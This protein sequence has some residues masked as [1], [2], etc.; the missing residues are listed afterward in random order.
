MN[1]LLD[2]H[3]VIVLA[4][5]AQRVSARETALLANPPGRLVVSAVSIWE[6][7]LKWDSFW[8]SCARKGPV[9]PADVLRV[10]AILTIDRLP[11]TEAHASADLAPAL[12]HSDP[13]DELLLAQAQEEGLKLLTRDDKL[14]THPCA[15]VA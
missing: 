4:G 14:K 9:S 5:K 13:F 6:I 3:Y 15:F 1:L 11:L 10:L 8:S 7:R 2:T 12:A